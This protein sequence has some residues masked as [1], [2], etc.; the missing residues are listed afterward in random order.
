MGKSMESMLPSAGICTT[1]TDWD[2][3]IMVTIRLYVA[4]ALSMFRIE[5][6]PILTDGGFP[7]CLSDTS[8]PLCTMRPILYSLETGEPCSPTFKEAQETQKVCE[9]V[10]ESAASRSW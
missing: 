9:A 1:R 8:I 3:L 4:G 5:I 10:I 6:S 2:I 7:G